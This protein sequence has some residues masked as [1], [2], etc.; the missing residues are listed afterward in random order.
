MSALP[1]RDAQVTRA[2]LAALRPALLVGALF[3][4]LLSGCRA[5]RPHA[6]TQLAVPAE[7]NAELVEY[8]SDL[9]YVTAESAYR[10]V[11]ILSKGE[12]FA[13]DYDALTAAMESEGLIGRGWNHDA[14]TFIDRA[15]VGHL[16]ARACGIRAGL[17]WRLTGLGRYAYRELIYRGI[18]H[19]SGEYGL[20]S[21]GEFLGLM[22]RAEEYLH[23][24]GRAPGEAAELGDEPLQP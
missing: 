14:D 3:A 6:T 23:K 5:A 24:V 20:I 13:G 15:A 22:A 2:A 12:I 7:T 9:P 21:G 1:P 4:L 8:I 11:Y 17:N 19:P 10:A 16:V 18:A